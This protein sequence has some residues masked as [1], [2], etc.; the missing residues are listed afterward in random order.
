MANLPKR[1]LKVSLV[2]PVCFAP[3]ALRTLTAR[4]F[5]APVCS[6]LRPSGFLTACPPLVICANLP[7][8]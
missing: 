3:F 2:F 5:S 7:G 1:I 8:D 6:L 4:T